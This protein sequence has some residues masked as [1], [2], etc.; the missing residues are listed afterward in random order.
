MRRMLA[1]LALIA[2]SCSPVAPQQAEAQAQPSIEACV[3]AAATHEAL[4]QCKSVVA[5]PC[6]DTPG[7]ETTYGMID[8]NTAE[9]EQWQALLD[10]E[11]ARLN[12]DDPDRSAAL[13]TSADAWSAWR[14]AECAYQASEY[15]GGSLAGVMSAVCHSDITADRAIALIWAQRSVIE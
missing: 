1:I 10:A 8:C 15:E 4:W 14:Q 3:T 11:I 7:G 2:A 5:S 12:A 9:A 13:T 6:L